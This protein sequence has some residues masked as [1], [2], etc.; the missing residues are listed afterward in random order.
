MLKGSSIY[1]VSGTPLTMRLHLIWHDPLD[2]SPN[3]VSRWAERRGYEINQ[4]YACNMEELPS[5]GDFDWLMVMGGS[6][7]VWQDK[8]YP[9]LPIEKAFIADV[10]SHDKIVLG[11]CFGS[12][13]I[14]EALGGRVFP[15]EHR[16][17]GWHEV[18]LNSDGKKSFLFKDV[19][20]TFMTFHWH[21]DHF[22]LPPGCTRLAYSEA[23]ANQAF[24]CDSRPVACV[25]FH[26]EFPKELINY[27]SHEYSD[28]WIPDRF[29]SGK[30]GVLKITK[31]I[32]DT[33]WLM[34]TLLDNMFQKFGSG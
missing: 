29:V 31:E 14:A 4:T 7:H 33:Y 20:N 30:E 27:F 18:F 21:G 5:I 3:N 19:P 6:Q 12:Q 8:I 1:L 22:S 16:E 34:E 17:I 15:N 26:P 25:Q 9:W 2:F 23:T 24:V 28:D 11:V 13:L 32:R 10:L